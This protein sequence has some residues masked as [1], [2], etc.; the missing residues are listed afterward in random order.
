MSKS[1]LY[2]LFKIGEIPLRLKQKLLSDGLIH[3]E[4]GVR[5]SIAYRNY[6]SANRYS[7]RRKV[8]FIAAVGFSKKLFLA[9]KGNY[10]FVDIP[11]D[12]E[13]WKYLKIGQ[14]KKTLSI[15]YDA[16]LFNPEE[17]GEIELRFHV[18]NIEPFRK[19]FNS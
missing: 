16:N 3:L 10:K 7:Y 19:L 13:K 11:L 1:I 5:A 6:K 12:N 4:E 2:R 14:F 17:S 15:S 9:T 8:G 18:D